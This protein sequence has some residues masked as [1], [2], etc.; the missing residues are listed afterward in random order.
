MLNTQVEHKRSYAQLMQK[1]FAKSSNLADFRFCVKPLRLSKT[2]VEFLATAL[3]TSV[4]ARQI[5]HHY[6]V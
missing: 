3:S 2:Y 1:I 4:Q 6:Q 5:K